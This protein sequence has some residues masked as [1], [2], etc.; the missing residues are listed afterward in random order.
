M[1]VSVFAAN[2]DK[3]KKHLPPLWAL[4]F[5]WKSCWYL[6]AFSINTMGQEEA[7]PKTGDEHVVTELQTALTCFDQKSSQRKD[8]ILLTLSNVIKHP[9]S[10]CGRCGGLK[11]L[12]ETRTKTIEGM[13]SALHERA[14]WHICM[15]GSL[16]ICWR[17]KSV[18]NTLTRQVLLVQQEVQWRAFEKTIFCWIGFQFVLFCFVWGILS[19]C[20]Q[21]ALDSSE[22]FR[23]LEC[24]SVS[25]SWFR[26]AT[27]SCS[28]K[29]REMAK[30]SLPRSEVGCS[31]ERAV[32]FFHHVECFQ[33]T[34]KHMKKESWI[35][36]KSTFTWQMS[37]E[38]FP[39][40]L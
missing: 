3:M 20:N 30:C 13:T 39:A 22:F 16:L 15:K 27:T 25:N 38:V 14:Q 34:R 4:C 28:A 31:Y 19:S 17:V 6:V 24:L 21:E 33:L 35:W 12:H 29:T 10:W 32:S 26:P 11:V 18:L 1:S 9:G 5:L 2:A 23:E 36:Y 37:C 8:G 40:W 7:A